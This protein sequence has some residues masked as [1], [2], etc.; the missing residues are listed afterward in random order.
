[1]INKIMCYFL[2][3]RPVKYEN[4]KIV[5]KS[6]VEHYVKSFCGR[7]KNSYNTLT[8]LE[9]TGAK[10]QTFKNIDV[11]KHNSWGQR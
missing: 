1:M 7:C 10:K 9:D 6:H 11:F 2:G 8:F 4:F 5:Y 3:H